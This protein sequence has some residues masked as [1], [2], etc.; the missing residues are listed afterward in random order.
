MTSWPSYYVLRYPDAK[1]DDISFVGVDSSS[2]GYPHPTD[3]LTAER[4]RT[5]QAAESY[6]NM[7]PYLSMWRIDSYGVLPLPAKKE[8]GVTE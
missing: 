8:L 4:W 2:G 5:F 3:F 7:F 1:S 6:R